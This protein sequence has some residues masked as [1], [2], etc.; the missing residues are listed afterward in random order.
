MDGK[1]IDGREMKIQEAKERRA[2]NPREHMVSRGTGEGQARGGHNCN[3]I[4]DKRT[5]RCRL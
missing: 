3:L 2:E 5:I 4:T 1:I